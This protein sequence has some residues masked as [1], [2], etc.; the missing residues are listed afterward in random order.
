MVFCTACEPWFAA[1]SER[2]ATSDGPKREALPVLGVRLLVGCNLFFVA[3][4]DLL[5]TGAGS[6]VT[7]AQRDHDKNLI[8]L[9][10]RCQSKG[11]KLNKEKFRL[12]EK[13]TQFMGYELT[14]SG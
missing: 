1:S 4:T 8:A 6:D 5:V 14:T 11:L 9:L 2:C 7:S 3:V 10:E 13:V 12:N